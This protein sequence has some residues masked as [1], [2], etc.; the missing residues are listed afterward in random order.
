V[1]TAEDFAGDR[2]SLVPE[3][4][5]CPCT[6]DDSRSAR[7]FDRFRRVGYVRATTRGRREV[8]IGGAAE[9]AP[10]SAAAPASSTSDTTK[11]I[12]STLQSFTTT[13]PECG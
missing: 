1:Q 7:G 4:L 9:R 6:C 2:L 5:C 10:S 11:T 8:S 13:R 12:R 3:A